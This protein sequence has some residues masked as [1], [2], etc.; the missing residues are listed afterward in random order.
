MRPLKLEI[1]GFTVYKKPQT[2]DFEK[3]NF[4]VIQGKTGSGKTSIVDAITYAL[5][6]KVPRYG[7]A[8]NTT[9][10]VLSKGSNKLRVALEFSVAGK[11]FKI[12]RFYREKPK[13]DV[14][15]VEEEGRKL[16]LKKT[17]IEDWVEKVTGLDYKTFTK[18]ILLPQGEFDRFLKP[19]S[20]K[21][22]REILIN[23]LNLEVF[24]KI[25]QLASETCRDME[26]QLK[27]LKSELEA[28]Q[29]VS[30][31]EI[32]K[33][34]EE[35]KKL[36][37][38]ARRLRKKL[39]ELEGDLVKAKEK[40]KLLGEK[41]DVEKELK[42]LEEK[43]REVEERRERLK[44]ARRIAPY[45]PFLERLE[46][47]SKE[48]RQLRLSKE[49]LQKEKIKREGELD[50]VR[51][52][53]ERV[54]REFSS[55]PKKREELQKLSARKEKLLMALQELSK[56]NQ[57]REE[58]KEKEKVLKE[59]EKLLQE[60][61]TRL[62]KGD[63]Y[64][65]QVKE[66]L[67]KLP[68]DEEAYER[69]IKEVERKKT[70]LE[71]K[72][73]LS[74]LEEEVSSLKKALEEEKKKLSELGKLLNEKEKKLEEEN[75]KLHAYHIAK[76]LKEGD[77]CPVCGGTFKKPAQPSQVQEIDVLREE[78]EK[79]RHEVQASERT[80]ASLEAS[81]DRAVKE[82]DSVASKLKGWESILSIDI[83]SKLE[84]MER[85][86]K[87]KV[88]LQEKLQKYTDRYNQLL[89]EKEKALLEVE[90]LRG[91][92]NSAK[93]SLIE[94]KEKVS[95]LLGTFMDKEEVS[96]ELASVEETI[97]HLEETIKEIE[98]RREE[99]KEYVE[100]L[101]RDLVAIDTKLKETDS[102]LR[103][104]EEEK[105]NI[106]LKL[107]PLYEELG[108]LEAVRKLALDE[109]TITKLE[110]E[111]SQHE[112]R[113]E[114]LRKRLEQLEE[115]LQKLG[116][117]PSLTSVEAQY[118]QVKRNLEEVIRSIGE[119]ESTI[120]QREEQLRRKEYLAKEVERIEKELLI[121]SRISEDLRSDRLQ[122][123]VAS[124]MLKRIVERASDYLYSFT[125]T[126][127]LETNSKG[128][129]VVIDH[130][131]GSERDV[132]SLSGGETFLASLSLA[133]GVSDVLSA[134]AHLESLFIDEG[135]GS[136]DEETRERVSD[137]L[138]LVKQRINRM[139]GI[140]SHIPDLAE[141]FHQRIV[142]KKH[143]DFSTVEVFY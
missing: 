85:L 95:Q 43:A 19:S 12:E 128:D 3:L 110:E 89:K 105:K 16:N 5:Y 34:K 118:E 39:E 79:L 122:D 106:T 83:E 66:Q 59:K 18:V 40:E 111:I 33:L 49:K 63:T 50:N 65:K 38:E 142:V 70:L 92:I 138:Q 87:E 58:I 84:E 136:L 90:K 37:E 125:N 42:S 61:E 91:E 56:A 81:L 74:Q 80:V 64:I 51:E 60:C 67:E 93:N 99:V 26:G 17:E 143:G 119:L 1:E 53:M 7:S 104:K 4:F 100:R 21:E 108:D 44:V 133:L 8:R 35:K 47:V 86:K 62:S 126:Y 23:L 69:L 31:K 137:I 20:P 113:I 77:P 124:L 52:E 55:L 116:E 96:E 30:P 115:D 141:R 27:V 131:Q 57:L 109:E 139:V 102:L 117:V 73:R 112:R 75:I 24:E 2:I 10:L 114:L 140:I 121:Y 71:E 15:R 123:F 68:F 13:E 135:F 45:L 98:R 76:H 6:G 9:S 25:R 32:D 132:K 103:K 36:E 94:A 28:L 11:R 41:E 88:S 72:S 127:H 48:I 130:A 14:V 129:L 29:E 54:E 82:R 97:S 78:I 46:E 120:S 107:A 22:R 101:S 134:Q